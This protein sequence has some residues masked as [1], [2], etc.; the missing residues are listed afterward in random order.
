[1][2]YGENW[3]DW[4]GRHAIEVALLNPFDWTAQFV[5]PKEL[6]GMGSP[7]PWVRGAFAVQGPVAMARL[8]TTAL[9]VYEAW[10]NGRR[11]GDENPGA[12]VDKL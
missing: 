8:Y 1:M 3:T 5:T 2:G 9:G 10:L 7:A 11:V 6:G 12:R 4:S